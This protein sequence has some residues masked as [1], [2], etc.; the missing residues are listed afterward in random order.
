MKLGK[1][2]ALIFIGICV[3]NFIVPELFGQI[4]EEVRQVVRRYR[5][6]IVQNMM[7]LGEEEGKRFW[8]VYKEFRQEA[9][10]IDQRKAA[11]ASKYFSQNMPLV[12]Y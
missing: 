11:S 8:P 1:S 12:E 9:K 5:Y 2:C 7:K 6:G 10:S 3:T 4:D